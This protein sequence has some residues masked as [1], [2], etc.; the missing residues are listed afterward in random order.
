MQYI[1][2]ELWIDIFNF[3]PTPDLCAPCFTSEAFLDAARHIINNRIL[4]SINWWRHIKQLPLHSR[5][6][7]QW[8]LYN[9]R[10]P[11]SVELI[12]HQWSWNRADILDEALIRGS[13]KTI[14]NLCANG[15]PFLMASSGRLGRTGN[16]EMIRWALNDPNRTALNHHQLGSLASEA[17]GS[18]HSH[19]IAWLKQRGLINDLIGQGGRIDMLTWLEENQIPCRF[20]YFK[21][22]GF[23]G[24]LSTLEWAKE[25]GITGVSSSYSLYKSA[26][27]AGCTDVMRYCFE[28]REC[29]P[30]NE[31]D[32]SEDGIIWTYNDGCPY[33][34]IQLAIDHK[35]ITEE[36]VMLMDEDVED[37]AGHDHLGILQWAV[38]NGYSIGQQSI[39]IA[40]ENGSPDLLEWLVEK[41][42]V[43]DEHMYEIIV[44][45]PARCKIPRS[46]NVLGLEWLL[47]RK[48]KKSEEVRRC[49][50]RECTGYRSKEWI[51]P[52]WEK[53]IEEERRRTKLKED[54]KRMKDCRCRSLLYK[55]T[56]TFIDG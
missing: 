47:Q 28:H 6:V 19:V 45:G 30:E 53:G 2:D 40:I 46:F 12:T 36:S 42:D 48:W 23:A 27:N 34:V 21:L 54:E 32:P 24:S 33:E 51:T 9:I 11:T 37:A 8:W 50:E 31:E 29:L 55:S 56:K 1:P 4:D 17:S 14:N 20:E 22:N 41:Y 7:I 26:L 5:D 25:H 38:E 3:L 13:K 35:M 18:G 15:D 39:D 16:L 44:A 49:V 10:E 52:L 43:K